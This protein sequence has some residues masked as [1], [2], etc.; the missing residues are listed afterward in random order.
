MLEIIIDLIPIN[1][2]FLGKRRR[3]KVVLAHDRIK[4][5][6]YGRQPEIGLLSLSE[7]E[8][9]P[10]IPIW[11]PETVSQSVL[12]WDGVKLEMKRVAKGHTKITL[13]PKT[14]EVNEAPLYT[15]SL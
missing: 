10:Q 1:V 4:I 11:L 13:L 8:A 3:G 12:L 5:A 14:I 7:S 15:S 2:N 6:L 9:H